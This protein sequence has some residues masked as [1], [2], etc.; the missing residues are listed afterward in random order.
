ML[1]GNVSNALPGIRAVID[2]DREFGP[3]PTSFL[4]NDFFNVFELVECPRSLVFISLY[5]NGNFSCGSHFADKF[6]GCSGGFDFSLVNDDDMI[7][8]HLHLMKNVGGEHD[9]MSFSE[10]FDQVSDGA[11]LI[12]VQAIG[13][14][15]QDEQFGFVDEGISKSHSLAITLGE[16]LDHLAPD[17]SQATQVHGLAD[18]LARSLASE[19]FEL[20][21]V[22]EIFPDPHVVIKGHVLGHVADLASGIDRITINVITGHFSTAGSGWQI[23]RE[24]SQCRGFSGPVRA[25]ETNDFALAHMKTDIVDSGMSAVSLAELVDVNHRGRNGMVEIEKCRKRAALYVDSVSG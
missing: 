11:N 25:E 7:T 17:M 22:A 3:V 1:V 18:V 13:W 24:H 4:S 20:G 15:I 8:G 23:T 12:W 16:G 19:T 2:Q 9:G 6:G 14:L 10:S 5:F 21:P